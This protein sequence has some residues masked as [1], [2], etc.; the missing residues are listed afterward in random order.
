MVKALDCEIVVREFEFQLG[1]YVHFWIN[2]IYGLNITT[3]I[4]KGWILHWITREG[5]YTIK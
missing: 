5:W 4:L 1:Y 2:T 3:T